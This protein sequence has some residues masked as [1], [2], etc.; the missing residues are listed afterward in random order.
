MVVDPS[1]ARD[2]SDGEEEKPSSWR[3][4]V[5]WWMRRLLPVKY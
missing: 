4:K 2:M 1:E 3:G 5:A